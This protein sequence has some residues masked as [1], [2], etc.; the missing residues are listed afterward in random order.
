ME[1][2]TRAALVKM[3]NRPPNVIELVYYNRQ[4]LV[5]GFGPDERHLEPVFSLARW[6]GTFRD[7]LLPSLNATMCNGSLRA[8]VD[9]AFLYIEDISESLITVFQ[10]RVVGRCFRT[11]SRV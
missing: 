2:L 7:S 4:V 6:V 9:Q 11:L 1:T 10:L 5:F 3:W 8:C